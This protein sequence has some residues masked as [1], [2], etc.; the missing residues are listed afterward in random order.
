MAINDATRLAYV[1]VLPDETRRST[2]ASL[3]RA[4]HWFSARGSVSS[5]G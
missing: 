4:L 5:G 2:T 1:E 3:V